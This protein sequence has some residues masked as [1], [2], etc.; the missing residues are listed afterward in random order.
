MTDFTLFQILPGLI[1]HKVILSEQGMMAAWQRPHSQLCGPVGACILHDGRLAWVPEMSLHWEFWSS[2]YPAPTLAFDRQMA[3]WLLHLHPRLTSMGT[4]PS[5]P[6]FMMLT[7]Q[8]F[9]LR[10]A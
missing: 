4:W 6:L 10:Q 2:P 3:E 8:S 1:K 5:L 9:P 7:S